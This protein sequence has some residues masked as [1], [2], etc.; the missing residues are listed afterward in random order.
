MPHAL[1]LPICQ[2]V[3]L[4]KSTLYWEEPLFPSHPALNTSTHI[5]MQTQR[6]KY[7]PLQAQT[8]FSDLLYTDCVWVCEYVCDCDK[9]ETGIVYISC[10]PPASQLQQLSPSRWERRINLDVWMSV[11]IWFALVNLFKCYW[12]HSWDN[13]ACCSFVCVCVPL[14][15]CCVCFSSLR[16]SSNFDS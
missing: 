9:R 6:Y 5:F 14:F 10:H 8:H 4:L 12:P 7:L 2:P 16:P 15:M 1:T 11:G 13:K 3:S